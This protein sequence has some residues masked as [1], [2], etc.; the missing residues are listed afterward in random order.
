[1]Q[2]VFRYIL[3]VIC[4][5]SCQ[6]LS[7]DT[8][9]DKTRHIVNGQEIKKI[10]CGNKYR[11]WDAIDSPLGY[12]FNCNG[13]VT[14][15]LYNYEGIRVFENF[16]Y[17]IT[18]DNMDYRISNDTLYFQVYKDYREYF[19]ILDL[20]N[21]S[22]HIVEINSTQSYQYVNSK[23]QSTFPTDGPFKD[24]KEV[25][26]LS[27]IIKDSVFFIHPDSFNRYL[28]APANVILQRLKDDGITGKPS[29]N[30]PNKKVK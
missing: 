22:L 17:E 3:I 9:I 4:L 1:M 20:S 2:L 29:S 6:F 27:I 26:S 8:N 19:K 13:K 24:P 5:Y 30:T 12:L 18:H 15:Y 16:N 28:D 14:R 7:K 21:D 23:D 11:F 25:D 10:L